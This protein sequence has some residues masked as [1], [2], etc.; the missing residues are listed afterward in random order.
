MTVH[1]RVGAAGNGTPA[2]LAAGAFKDLSRPFGAVWDKTRALWMYPAFY[3]AAKRVL[4]D[5][6]VL[7]HT[8]PLVL[9]DTVREHTRAVEEVAR[10]YE[11]RQLPDGFEFVTK[12]FEHQ[13]EGV[14]H[15]YYLLRSG[16]FYAPG[17]GKSKIAVD[18]VRLRRFLGSRRTTLVFGPLTTVRNW[19]REIDRHSDRTLSWVAVHGS[20]KDKRKAIEKAAAE[21]ADIVLVTYDSARSLVD[22]IVETLDYDT[23]FLDE[24]HMVKSWMSARTRAAYEIVQKAARRVLLTGSPTQGDPDD[25]YGQYR[26]LGDCFMPEDYKAYKLKFIETSGPNSHVVVGYKNLDILNRRTTFL[27]LEK[28]KEECLDLP[29]RTVV[30]VEYELTRHQKAIHNQLVLSL[31]LDPVLLAAQLGGTPLDRIPPEARLPHRAAMLI[32][33]LQVASGFLVKNN[34]DSGFCDVAEPGGCRWRAECVAE[35]VLPHTKGCKVDPKPLPN[36]ITVFEENPKL[37]VALELL[38]AIMANPAHKAIVWC[39]F[40]QELDTLEA[41]V[42][43]A[44]WGYVRVDGTTGNRIQDAVDAFNDD[45][46]VR[47]Y[48]AQ[49]AT[50]VG[51]TLN[52]AQY[53]IYMSLPFSLDKYDQ[54]LDRNYR[55]GQ[56]KNVTVYRLLGIGTPEPAITR[57]LDAKVDVNKA[58]TRKLDCLICPHSARC[59]EARVEIFDEEC[60]HSKRIARPVIKARPLSMAEDP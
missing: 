31:E 53:M 59:A 20:P 13:I 12:P 33:L 27:S 48:I 34:T 11:A 1:V 16:L 35:R 25:L 10:R 60:I 46:A 39:V 55:I 2:F 19:G 44:G 54:S 15:A 51:I 23:V 5:F 3:P 24:S 37:D 56:T 21:H 40:T 8:V 50:G 43:E 7:A 29:E 14:C 9:S 17:L 47:L 30:D 28:T 18:Q 4:E 22:D 32:K 52:A 26:I 49:V 38:E 6:E 41:K 42:K 58:L 57:L 36:T 45:P